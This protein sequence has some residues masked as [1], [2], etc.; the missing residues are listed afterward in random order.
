[1]YGFWGDVVIFRGWTGPK[2][3][4][5]GEMLE[6][7]THKLQVLSWT[8]SLSSGSAF[9]FPDS[10]A[11]VN[12]PLVYVHST[13]NVNVSGSRRPG[14]KLAQQDPTT[15]KA[16]LL[17]P[18]KR[19]QTFLGP[20]LPSLILVKWIFP[21]YK[22]AG[23]G[24]LSPLRLCISCLQQLLHSNMKCTLLQLRQRIYLGIHKSINNG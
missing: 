12:P 17:V 21:V 2:I 14:R 11:Y 16:P 19:L 5:S 20:S 22:S 8:P 23:K 3:H 24:S 4:E 1:M 9:L 18:V 6:E 13:N 10:I 15:N 7:M